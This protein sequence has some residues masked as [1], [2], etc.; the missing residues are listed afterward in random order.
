MDFLTS[1]ILSGIIYDLIKEGMKLSIN[2]VFASYDVHK[3]DYNICEEFIEKINAIEDKNDKVEYANEL[4]N[5]ENK[6]TTLFEQQMYP[7]NFSK[8]LDYVLALMNNCGYLEDKINVERLGEYLGF[9]SV[10]SAT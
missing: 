5:K 7:T 8:R 10:V 4:L 1:T 3:M 6:Y 2:N 9:K